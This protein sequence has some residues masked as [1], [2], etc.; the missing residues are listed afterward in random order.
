[1]KKKK[2]IDIVLSPFQEFIKNE[3]AGGILLI[4]ATVIALVWANSGF[5]DLYKSIWETKFTIG[6]GEYALS[7]PIILWIND[8]LMAIFFFV[9]GLEIKRELLVGELSSISKAS[10]PIAAAIGGMLVPA[11]IYFGFNSSSESLSGWAIPTATDIAFAIGIL[12]LLG[13]RVPTSLK[14]FLTALAIVDDIGAVLVIAIFYT[15]EIFLGYLMWAGIIFALMFMFN[16]LGVR[17]SLVYFVLGLVMWLM[18]LKS[19]I[20]A[21]IAGVIGAMAIPAK[22]EL[23]KEQFINR[24]T[25]LLGKIKSIV[26]GRDEGESSGAIQEMENAVHEVESPLQRLEHSLHYL[27][28]FFI[29]PVFALA[30]AGVIIESDFLNS[31]TSL[32]TLG[33]MLGLFVGKQIGITI[34]TYL[35]VKFKVA[36][37]PGD[38]SWRQ[39][40]GAAALAGIGFTMS[41]FITNLAFA[42]DV[43]IAEAKVGIL[44]GSLLSGIVGWIVLTGAGKGH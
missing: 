40:Y 42:S 9:V 31:F 10:L 43:F 32:I 28:S 39:I 15:S 30:N 33:V 27:V 5:G 16:K 22:T 18:F 35:A 13:S 6:F 14:V 19:G 24:I 25:S 8:G 23:N 20:H 37:L 3:A 1:M 4:A 41:L 38:V 11:L 26:Q 2:P 29:M 17:S 21:T 34:F 44:A 12:A 7:K 36:L